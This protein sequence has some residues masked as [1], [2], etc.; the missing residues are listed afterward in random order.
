MAKEQK[1][2][3]VLDTG[4]LTIPHHDCPPTVEG[5]AVHL[6]LDGTCHKCGGSC[7]MPV[8]IIVSDIQWGPDE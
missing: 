8:R 5:G 4:S 1:C 6:I 7:A 3:H 2:D